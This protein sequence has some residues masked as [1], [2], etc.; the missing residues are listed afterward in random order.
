MGDSVDVQMV[1]KGKKGGSQQFLTSK[2]ISKGINWRQLCGAIFARLRLFA[3]LP[4]AL[5]SSEFWQRMRC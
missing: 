3:R 1:A 2:M 5:T 4:T